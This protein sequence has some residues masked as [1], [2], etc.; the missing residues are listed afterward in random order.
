MA[1]GFARGL[2]V[3]PVEP[4]LPPLEDEGGSLV[5]A[6]AP[7]CARCGGDHLA[8]DCPNLSAGGGE[9]DPDAEG[10]R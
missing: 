2:G 7:L 4:K 10:T 1:H 9:I 5:G 6:A 8:A 3:E